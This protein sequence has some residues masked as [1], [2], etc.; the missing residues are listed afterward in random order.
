MIEL[1]S[2]FVA[3]VLYCGNMGTQHGSS[4]DAADKC[5]GPLLA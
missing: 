5:L 3:P 2:L 1:V 4:S